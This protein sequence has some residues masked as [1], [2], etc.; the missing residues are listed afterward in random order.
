MVRCL[1]PQ[2]EKSPRPQV[3]LSFRFLYGKNVD[4]TAFVIFGVQDGDKKISLAHSLKRVMVLPHP[5]KSSEWRPLPR[6]HPPYHAEPIP[7][8][9]P[10]PSP[11]PCRTRPP[12]LSSYPS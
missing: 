11:I 4:G 9:S 7:P 1:Q 2:P 5:F 3:S 12:I 6:D 10:T 8:L